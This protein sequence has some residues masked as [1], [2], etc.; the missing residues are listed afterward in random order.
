MS[1]LELPHGIL[2]PFR[3][4]SIRSTARNPAMAMVGSSL[5]PAVL[6]LALALPQEGHGPVDVLLLVEIPGALPMR[7]Y[8]AVPGAQQTEEILEAARAR[9]G[10]RCGESAIL[11]CLGIGPAL[12]AEAR[13][14][15]QH[16]PVA[17]GAGRRLVAPGTHAPGDRPC[18][19]ACPLPRLHH[20][21]ARAPRRR[22]YAAARG[23]L[24]RANCTPRPPIWP[25]GRAHGCRK[26]GI[27][28]R[29]PRVRGAL[30]NI[31]LASN[32]ANAK[33]K[34]RGYNSS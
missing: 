13:V 32:A 7:A 6:D 18:T 33:L 27:I 15:G 26:E 8:P 9:Y 28:A 4:H 22:E 20:A 16:R 34:V 24:K 31:L 14:R 2:L 5:D 30:C 1:A 25:G 23:P 17:G 12:V 3:P 21:P 10:A 29:I 19:G 11:L